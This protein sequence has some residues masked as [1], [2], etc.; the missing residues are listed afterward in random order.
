M[1]AKQHSGFRY[2]K[3][4]SDNLLFFTHK[5]SDTLNEGKKLLE[6][7]LTYLKLSIRSGIMVLSTN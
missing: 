5:I 4:A 6:S 7:S 1:I 3:K 2:N